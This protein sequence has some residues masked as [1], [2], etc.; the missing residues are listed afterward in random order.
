MSGLSLRMFGG[1]KPKVD[2]HLLPDY[3]AQVAN[4][5]RLTS[6]ALSA[7]RK[8]TSIN[9]PSK[10]GTKISM[11]RI[12]FGGTD[13]WLHWTTN[14]KVVKSQIANDAFNRY[15]YTGDGTPKVTTDQL[16]T[17]GAGTLYPLAS[18][19]LGLPAPTTPT[20]ASIIGGAAANQTRTY[21]YTLVSAW[22]EEGPPSLPV[23]GTGKADATWTV[24]LPQVAQPGGGT[25]QVATKNLYRSVTQADGSV[26][27]LLV[28][29][30]IALAAAS[31]ADAALDAALIGGTVLPSTTWIMPPTGLGGLISLPNGSMAGY[32]NNQ[33]CLSEPFQ[34]HAWPLKYRYSVD[35]PIVGICANGN[36][37]AVCTT[38]NPYVFSG[39][40]PDAMAS[41]K[42]RVPEPCLSERSI[43]DVGWGVLYA[44]PNGLV[45]AM[46]I[47]AEIVTF[48]SILP[49]DWKE[50]Y[51]PS[52]M[53][54][55]VYQ[56][57][58]YG[59]YASG[60]S[61]GAGFVIDR[62]G[63]FGIKQINDVATGAWVDPSTGILY[64]IISGVIVQ[65]DSDVNNSVTYQWRSKVFVEPKPLNYGVIQVSADYS[66]I[67]VT[68]QQIAQLAI[69]QAF[70]AAMLAAHTDAG[71]LGRFSLG[72]IPLGGSKLHGAPLSLVTRFVQ[73]QVFANGTLKY[74]KNFTDRK[75]AKLP[76]GFKDDTYEVEISGNVDCYF[77]K[78][79]ENAKALERL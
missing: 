11:Y 9:T 1:V 15:Y 52:T 16:A 41:V 18:F 77:V 30:G 2:S 36:S 22:G 25:F 68:Q 19:T 17:Q 53:F 49:K 20:I 75:A 26:L 24:N 62:T 44:S 14:V 70:N 42:A 54:G 35:F 46:S 5:C 50:S 69:D 56:S 65:W 23:I 33:L 37:I 71:E 61:T 7:W 4:N 60:P 76:S 12:P 79:A 63:D 48:S 21:V 72:E 6:G 3:L 8:Y 47:D 58:Y 34:P 74:S 73:V 55:T 29:S 39:V 28:S 59:F 64:L 40:S 45:N 38:A 10:P 27:F 78:L 32:V 67:G 13:Y 66:S 57:F 51:F 31:F 43:V